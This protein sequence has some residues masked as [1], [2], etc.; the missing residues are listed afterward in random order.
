M[1]QFHLP[2]QSSYLLPQWILPM[3]IRLYLQLLD[4]RLATAHQCNIHHPH[5]QRTLVLYTPKLGWKHLRVSNHNERFG[6]LRYELS[7]SDLGLYRQR[8]RREHYL[9]QRTD[10]RLNQLAAHQPKSRTDNAGRNRPAST[11][12]PQNHLYRCRH[13]NCHH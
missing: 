12:Y 7:L 1:H 8:N 4:Q 2:R 9:P 3:P 13:C 6:Q 11:T 5:F 10:L